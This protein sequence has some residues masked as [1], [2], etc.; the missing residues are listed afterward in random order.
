MGNWKNRVLAVSMACMCWCSVAGA[1]SLQVGD[2]GSDVAEVQAEL[3]RIGYDVVADG[4]FGPA[5]VEAIK[6]FQTAH[7]MEVDGSVGPST[8]EALLGKEMPETVSRGSNYVSR[9]IVQ[10]AMA[11]LGV[12]YSFGGTSP[13]GFDCS[14]YVRFVFANAGIYLPRA[15]DEQ[16]EVG[17]PVP[18]SA[19]RTGDLVFFST[20]EYGASHVGI[21]LSDGNFIHAA[22]SI[23]VSIAS[24]YDPYYWGDRYIGARRVL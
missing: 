4:D 13:S 1:E 5:T 7:G 23:G 3:V 8:Y 15:A 6:D 16:Y 14:G 24:I 19:L 11:Y 9:R 2:Q 20:Y 17:R 18:M 21:Y 22:S 12:P 10:T